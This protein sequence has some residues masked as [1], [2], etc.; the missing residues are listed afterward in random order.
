MSGHTPVAMSWSTARK[1]STWTPLRSMIP[2]AISARPSVCEG[3]GERF[4]VQLMKSARR[5]EKSHGAP[6][7]SS[8]W[9]RVR[10]AM[11]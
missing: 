5:S 10:E 9:R 8:S 6:A 4:S 11:A 2:M 3:S 7:A 1:R